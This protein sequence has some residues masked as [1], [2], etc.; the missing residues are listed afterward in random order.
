VPHQKLLDE[1]VVIIYSDGG[2]LGNPGPGGY[3]VVL[4]YKNQRK[5]LSQGYMLPT[6]NRMELLGSIRGLEALKKPSRVAFYTDSQYVV[7]G[8]TKGW[9]KKWQAN[10]W[11]RSVT[12]EAKNADLWK[13]LLE[14]CTSHEVKFYWVRGHVGVQENERCD[15]LATQSARQRN[16]L[17]DK[18]YQ[19]A[20]QSSIVNRQS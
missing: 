13:Q 14:L 1:G 3:G 8:I 9:A 6:N 7:N 15:E 12:Q 19:G 10:N 17:I 16:L 18:G 5:E 2:C 4:L 11:M 20:E